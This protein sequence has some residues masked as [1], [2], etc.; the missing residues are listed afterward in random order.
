MK[1]NERIIIFIF[2]VTLCLFAIIYIPIQT[3]ALFD[4][5]ILKGVYVN[6]EDVGL[7]PKAH[8]AENLD[9]KFNAQLQNRTLT[10]KYN[11]FSITKT[12]GDFNLKYNIEEAVN[13]AFSHGKDEKNLINKTLKRYEPERYDVQLDLI[14]DPTAIEKYISV[15]TEQINKSP[16]DATMAFKNNKFEI[17]NETLGEQVDTEKLKGLVNDALITGR[18]VVEIPV[19]TV[20]PKVTA[21]ALSKASQKIMSFTTYLTKVPNRTT[22]IK[23]AAKYINGTLLAPGDIFSANNSI[24]PRT[25]ERGFKD[26]GIFANGKVEQGIGGGICQVS[27][28]IYN[29]ALLCNFKII[30]RYNHSLTVTYVPLGRDSS[31]SWGSADFKFQNTSNY[32]VYIQ[33][34]ADDKQITVNFYGYNENPGQKVDIVVESAEVNGKMRYKTYRKVYQN[35]KLLKSELLSNDYYKPH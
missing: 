8:A 25:P 1:K 5:L 34:L 18:E 32:P 11:G 9:R 14:Y 4:R 24:G 15:I 33:T 22:N 35:G 31:I 27:S 30:E 7:L 16:V 28:T 19:T 13:E 17:T 12:Y 23:M 20:H 21:E 10:L 3:T 26:A 6:D 29:A 2:S